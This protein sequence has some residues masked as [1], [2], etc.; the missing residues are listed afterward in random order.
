MA[1]T[2]YRLRGNFSTTL[3]ASPNNM[4]T[5]ILSFKVIDND[6]NNP[7]VLNKFSNISIILKNNLFLDKKIEFNN[8]K[9]EV[10]VKW[11]RNSKHKNSYT[12]I[13]VFPLGE[14]DSY[15]LNYIVKFL[16]SANFPG[17]GE[18]K[19]KRLVSDL[20]VDV[21]A[22]M[23]SE[24]INPE[25]YGIS[26]DNWEISIDYLKSN[27]S[28]V[29]DQ[30]YFLKLNLSTSLYKN[31]VKNFDNYDN[32]LKEYHEDFYR[33]YFENIKEVRLNDIDKIHDDNFKNEN[34]EAKWGAHIYS[35]LIK[36]CFDSGNTRIASKKVFDS[37]MEI[38]T[39]DLLIP[40]NTEDFYQGCYYLIKNKLLILN[41]YEDV[42]YLTPKHVFEIEK[43][44]VDRIRL[45]KESKPIYKFDY[46]KK[47]FFDDK[48]EEAIYSALN[49]NLVL[50]T[51]SPGTGKTLITNEIIRQLQKKYNSD[52]IVVVTP[53]GRATINI[54]N[55]NIKDIQA[56]TIHSFLQW[57]PDNNRFNINERHPISCECLIIDEFSM[58]SIDIFDALLKGINKRYLKKII[59]V[60]DKDQLPAIGPGYL[61]RD[62]IENNIF[63]TIELDKIY[64][65]ADNFDIVV[66]AISINKG[67]MPNFEG[68]QSQFKPTF[69][70]DL[71][72]VLIN[73]IEELLNKGYTKKD[74]AVLSPIYNYET[75]IDE[76]NLALSNYY[77]QKEQAE[78]V[79]HRERTFAIGDKV[80][81]LVNDPKTKTFNGEIGYIS[82]FTF[83]DKRNT[84]EQ[85]LSHITVQYEI[86]DKLVTYTRKDFVENT[87]MAYCTSVHK[88][89]GSECP[90]V[91]TVLF[92]EAK[93]L[94]SKKLIYTAVTR[95]K[96]LSVIFGEKNALIDGIQNDDDSKRITNIK[97]L[98]QGE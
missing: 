8:K 68:Q 22:K 89:Q 76:I 47:S 42:E 1:E 3:W 61:I 52:D 44:I 97:L 20:G 79:K 23:L 98:W 72:E 64:R 41:F 63:K 25:K 77:R 92:S 84:G 94:L 39:T 60:G 75:G 37:L 34:Q 45:I 93:R 66:D 78:V 28:I 96:H 18:A 17:I 7:I 33:F 51:G 4:E 21:L 83:I 85:E 6:I 35:A 9:Y 27:P 11:N 50:I 71:K 82:R 38:S 14:D 67:L 30:I 5:V 49:D 57:D 54:N 88:Y 53:T 40:R 24:D 80:I 43:S 73:K 59:L 62:F 2:T 90:I 10:E 74:I 86:Y 32:F 55:K 36:Y 48:Q 16:K 56:V 29:K 12:C 46:Q 65:Q 58:V 87:N 70:D 91:L 19:A 69:R 15:K 95:A 13:D 26:E 31:I 81:N